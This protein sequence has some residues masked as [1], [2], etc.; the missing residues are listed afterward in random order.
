[1]KPDYREPLELIAEACAL[2]EQQIAYID[3][4]MREEAGSAGSA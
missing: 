3:G 1:M 4:D 2:L